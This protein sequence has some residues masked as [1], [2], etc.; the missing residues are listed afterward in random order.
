[1]RLLYICTLLLLC[2]TIFGA[3]VVR[4]LDAPDTNISGL[5]YGDGKLWCLDSG[6]SYCYGLNPVT[7]NVETSFDFSGYSTYTPAGLTYNGTHLFGS[8]INGGSSPYIYWYTTSGTYTG[9][10]CIC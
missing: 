1:M 6:S 5:A 2:T 8:F 9:N 7:G 10:D 4:T 3:E